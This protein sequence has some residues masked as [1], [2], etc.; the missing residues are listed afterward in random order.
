MFLVT[1]WSFRFWVRL[2]MVVYVEGVDGGY[3]VGVVEGNVFVV[4]VV[5]ELC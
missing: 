5:L 2:M 1:Q 3:F 4:Q